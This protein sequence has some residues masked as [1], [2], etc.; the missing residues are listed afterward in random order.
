[1]ARFAS[2]KNHENVLI[3]FI[4]NPVKICAV[5]L[6]RL[7]KKKLELKTDSLKN[8]TERIQKMV[9]VIFNTLNE[10]KILVPNGVDLLFISLS[11]WLQYTK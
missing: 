7:L 11:T 4:N 9:A 5:G 6:M 2:T 10:A 1:M 3:V 8:K